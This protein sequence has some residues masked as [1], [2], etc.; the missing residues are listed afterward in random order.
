GGGIIA[1]EVLVQLESA[2]ADYV[3]EQ[4]YELKSLAEVE[5][6]I[7][8]KKHLP[9]VVSAKEVAENGLNLGEMQRAQ[10]EKIE[11][12][13]LHLIALEKRVNQLEVENAAL[14]ATRNK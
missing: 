6:F 7:A 11:E 14:K 1:E 8:Q 2:W 3:F 9:G 12:L 4:D 10:M 13:Y 5:H